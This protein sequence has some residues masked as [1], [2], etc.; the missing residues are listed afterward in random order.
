MDQ[1]DID[2]LVI[3]VGEM[4]YTIIPD[5]KIDLVH[6]R[7]IAEEA[8]TLVNEVLMEAVLGEFPAKQVYARAMQRVVHLLPE[9]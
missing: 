2:K 5:D 9:D 6:P 8:Q 7:Q 3:Q 1:R 4:F